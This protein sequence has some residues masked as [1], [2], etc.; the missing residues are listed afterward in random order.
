MS[1]L[2][3]LRKPCSALPRERFL[4][5]FM[6]LWILSS[7]YHHVVDMECSLSIGAW[8]FRIAW[9]AFFSCILMFPLL[10]LTRRVSELRQQWD[11]L[12]HR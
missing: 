6:F 5:T 7:Y 1:I 10:S 12:L 3:A 2:V 8:T 11:S 9:N 4:V